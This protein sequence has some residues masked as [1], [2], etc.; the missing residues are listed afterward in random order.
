MLIIIVLVFGFDDYGKHLLHGFSGSLWILWRDFQR[1]FPS[2]VLEF[3]GCAQMFQEI[4]G[5][6][7]VQ[8]RFHPRSTGATCSILCGVLQYRSD[9]WWLHVMPASSGKLALQLCYILYENL[10]GCY[11][12]LPYFQ[13]GCS[14][15]DSF[16]TLRLEVYDTRLF[17]L[18]LANKWWCGF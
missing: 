18:R 3:Q 1:D 2:C 11:L 5:F 12:L 17:P 15:S 7:F 6:Y 8:A 9:F 14:I 13:R 4:I 16:E 10:R